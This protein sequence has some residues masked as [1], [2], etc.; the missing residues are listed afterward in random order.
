MR[1]L[2]IAIFALCAPATLLSALIPERSPYIHSVSKSN[3]YT[4]TLWGFNSFN[5][6]CPKFYLLAV[7][8]RGKTTLL[9]RRLLS[10]SN[11]LTLQPGLTSVSVSVPSD[12]LS[13][14]TLLH[15]YVYDNAG[16]KWTDS[17]LP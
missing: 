10:C 14:K 16:H 6:R 9:G 5:P 15:T 7:E 4:Y 8:Y 2:I 12:D 17:R 1:N 11:V 13:Y 3:G